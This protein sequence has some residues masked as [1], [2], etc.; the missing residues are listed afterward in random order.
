MDLENLEQIPSAS[1]LGEN[2]YVQKTEVV[3]TTEDDG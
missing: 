2:A 1:A 3:V